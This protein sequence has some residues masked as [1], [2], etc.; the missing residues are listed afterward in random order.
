MP[1]FLHHTIIVYTTLDRTVSDS[2][3][4]VRVV[5]GKD[6]NAVIYN[7]MAEYKGAPRIQPTVVVGAA[8]TPQH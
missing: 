3:N 8:H 4:S 7:Q 1:L 2:A 6:R 5:F